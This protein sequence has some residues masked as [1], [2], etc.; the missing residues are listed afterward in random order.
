MNDDGG[1]VEEVTGHFRRVLLCGS[2]RFS[3]ASRISDGRSENGTETYRQISA[4]D[5]ATL[6]IAGAPLSHCEHSGFQR[7]RVA[8][9]I[10]SVR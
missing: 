2:I 6:S 5:Q 4:L 9:T 7:L 10:Y 8:G 1:K 3:R